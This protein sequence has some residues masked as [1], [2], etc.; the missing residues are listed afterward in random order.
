MRHLAPLALALSLS[1]AAASAEVPDVV[2]DTA[3]TYALV[4]T[5]MGDLGTPTLLL[6][7]GADAHDYQLRPSQIR[8]LNGAGLVIWLGPEMT[9][10]LD[11]AIAPDAKGNTLELLHVPGTHLR[12]YEEADDDHEAEAE[13]VQAADAGGHRHEGTDPHAWLDPDNAALWL[14]QIA[15]SLAQRDPGNAAVYRA[16]ASLAQT[17]VHTMDEKIGVAMRVA[18]GKPLV[19]AHAAYGYFADHYGL[20]IAASIAEG[21]AAA[22]GA[23]HLA[24]IEAL[25][26]SGEVACV[27]PEVLRDP[28]PVLAL[29]E[30]AGVKVG[31]ALDPEG[32]LIEPGAGFYGQLMTGLAGAIAACT[33]TD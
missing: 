32:R 19:V 11:Q 5:V 27:F 23:A 20:T 1:A 8:A 30:A 16:N 21:D 15:D 14:G 31:G 7:L 28:K 6:D 10:W 13:H 18:K 12:A 29:A 25:L 3:V 4:A 2:A 33:A 9:P 17:A 22:P 26:A 24:E